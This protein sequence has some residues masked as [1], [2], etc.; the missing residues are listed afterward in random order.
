M[1]IYNK[2]VPI[3]IKHLG[4]GDDLSLGQCHVMTGKEDM[5]G[6]ILNMYPPSTINPMQVPLKGIW[7][8][9]G[10]MMNKK[11]LTRWLLARVQCCIDRAAR[12]G[13]SLSFALR[14][15]QHHLADQ[16]KQKLFF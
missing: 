4:T 14:H 15:H 8:V 3:T 16:T 9:V 2:Q 6:S 11:I 1:K 5:S 10:H 12:F 13:C 7:T